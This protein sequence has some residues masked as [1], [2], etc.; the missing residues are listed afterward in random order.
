MND[1]HVRPFNHKARRCYNSHMASDYY[2][3]LGVPRGASD[4]DIKKAYRR[5]AMEFHPDRNPGKEKEA[6]EKFKQINEAY[7]ILGDPDKRKQYDQF[8]T[9]GDVGDIFGSNNTR[10]TFEDIIRDFGGVGLGLGFLDN[11]FGEALRGKGYRVSFGG[12]GGPTGTRSRHAGT[13]R[14]GSSSA[15]QGRQQAPITVRYELSVTPEEA[16]SGTRKRLT[17]KGRRIEVTVP[18]G[19]VTGSTVKLTGACTVTDGCQG[20]I[21]VRIKV[22]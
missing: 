8:G 12:M 5:L 9:V 6:T 13:R 16:Q 11:I 20:D 19:V 18:P 3:V 7:G 21:L 15:Q 4:A 1:L 17:R 14:A 10:A 2:Q 22:K